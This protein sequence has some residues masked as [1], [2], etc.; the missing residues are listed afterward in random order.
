MTE[1]T[2]TTEYVRQGYLFGFIKEQREEAASVFD[3][4]LAAHD[5]EVRADECEQAA[6]RV[7]LLDFTWL[8]RNRK[9]NRL[10]KAAVAA[11]RGE[12]NTND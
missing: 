3:R 6:M 9:A 2:P 5:A 8:E 12:D 10:W 7:G 11:A 4:W 1:Y